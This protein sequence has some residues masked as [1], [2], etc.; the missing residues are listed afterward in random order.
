MKNTVVTAPFVEEIVLLPFRA[1]GTVKNQIAI[2]VQ[3]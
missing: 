3:I 1:Y 2:G